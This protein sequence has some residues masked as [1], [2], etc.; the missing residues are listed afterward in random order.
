MKRALFVAALVFAGTAQ[1]ADT[2]YLAKVNGVSIPAAA[3]EQALSEARAAGHKDT[4]ELRAMLAQRLIAEELFWQQAT[5]LKLQ[6]TAE[7]SVA[8]DLARR[9]SA[10]GQYIQRNVKPGAPDEAELH[11]QYERTVASL[12]PREYRISLIQT[13]NEAALRALAQHLASGAD[14]A[15]EARRVSEVPSAEKGGAIGWLSF[16]V[17]LVAGRTNGMPISVAQAILA[18]K[19]GAVSPPLPVDDAWALVRL[20]D[21]RAT[22]APSFAASRATLIEAAQAQAIAA[23]GRDLALRLIRGAR[24]EVNPVF[25]SA[26]SV[27][28]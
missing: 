13:T 26:A 19:P 7:A 20:D 11:R 1:A 2:S 17:P 24:I 15:T 10:I 14:F 23:A 9:K 4:P 8:A 27:Q 18:L 5:K 6:N 22:Q 28:P 12:G 3:L 25:T 16:P 21:E